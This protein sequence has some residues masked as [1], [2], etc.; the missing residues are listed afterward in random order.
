MPKISQNSK[1]AIATRNRVR[2]HRRVKL[3]LIKERRNFEIFMNPNDLKSEEI[4]SDLMD[5][6][7]ESLR[8]WALEHRIK[9][10]ALSDLLKILKSLGLNWLPSDSRSFLQTPRKIQ[11]QNVAGGKLWYYG[12]RKNLSNIFCMLTKDIDVQLNFNIDGMA[13]FKSSKKQFWPILAS[14]QG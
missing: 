5:S 14:I 3:I 10:S 12:I 6:N 11:I 7:R 13:P 4:R 9:R 2:L 8:A 1:R